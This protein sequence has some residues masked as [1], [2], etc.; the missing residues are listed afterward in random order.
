MLG[1]RY[2]FSDLVIIADVPSN[3]AMSAIALAIAAG[4]AINSSK[5]TVLMT[6]S[7]ILGPEE[8]TLRWSRSCIYQ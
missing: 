5:T 4:G 3:E 7:E 8:V 6:G 1:G 2:C